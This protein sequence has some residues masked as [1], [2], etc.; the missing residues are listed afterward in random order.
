MGENQ[1]G[2]GKA[3]CPQCKREIA[4]KFMALHLRKKHGHVAQAPPPAKLNHRQPRAAAPHPRAAKRGP[5][6][7]MELGDLVRSCF[8]MAANELDL[9]A[10]L[11][12]ACVEGLQSLTAKTKALRLAYLKKADALRKLTGE[13]AACGAGALAGEPDDLELPPAS[14]AEGGE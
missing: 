8:S 11:V 4:A 14:N 6:R 12:A 10:A 5:A 9:Q 1:A 13:I 7:V 2:P 3:T